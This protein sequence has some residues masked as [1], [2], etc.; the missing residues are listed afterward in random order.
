MF[1]MT[2][3]TTVGTASSVQY[4]EAYEQ[5]TGDVTFSGNL[6]ETHQYIMVFNDGYSVR[7]ND[8]FVVTSEAKLTGVDP[9][10][11]NKKYLQTLSSGTT[12]FYAYAASCNISDRNNIKVE[13]IDSSGKTAATSRYESSS[14]YHLMTA[15]S[16]LSPGSY[17][18]K[19]T[20]NNLVCSESLTVVS[21]NEAA[22]QY[23]FSQTIFNER[24]YLGVSLESATLNPANLTYKVVMADGTEKEAVYHRGLY[25]NAYD[26]NYFV[27]VVNEALTELDYNNSATLQMYNGSS[28]ITPT[29]SNNVSL[30]YVNEVDAP[31]IYDEYNTAGTTVELFVEGLSSASGTFSICAYDD[32]TKTGVSVNAASSSETSVVFNKSDLNEIHTIYPLTAENQGSSNKEFYIELNG[33][34][35]SYIWSYGYNGLGN[36]ILDDTFGFQNAYTNRLYE[37]LNLPHMTY[38]SY[39][40]A[41]SESELASKSYQPIEAGLL[42]QLKNQTEAQTVYAQFKTSDGAESDV[43]TA[44]ITIDTVSPAFTILSE[45]PEAFIVDEYNQFTISLEVN[46]DEAGKIHYDFYDADNNKIGYDDSTSSVSSG[47][48]TASRSVYAG[49]YNYE[50][51]ATLVIYMTD[52]AGNKS[53]EYSFPVSVF[54]QYTEYTSGE[55]YLKINNETGMIVEAMST[56]TT[57]RIPSEINGVDVTSIGEYAVYNNGEALRISIPETVTSIDAY[58]FSDLNE[59]TLLVRENSAALSYAVANDIPYEIVPYLEADVTKTTGGAYSVAVTPHTL[60]SANIVVA[61]YLNGRL[62]AFDSK[63]YTGEALDFSISEAIDEVKVMAWESLTTLKPLCEAKAVHG[64]KFITE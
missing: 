55:T 38:A 13:L 58:A 51:A 54:R 27:V 53:E 33:E 50:D 15:A 36:G 44:S 29:Y 52:L 48:S 42:Y 32:L 41:A 16:P 6:D 62:V 23:V 17:T 2:T 8:A 21:G 4:D 47:T 26:Y 3:G 43:Q 28:F 57:L 10:D 40:L 22:W 63:A 49:G 24:T 7:V 12:S 25:T 56:G 59:F 45:V 39:R 18:L 19:A 34:Y 1:D 20:Y 14:S 30:S 64:R 9:Y 60:D 61:G 31:F 37:V 5:I 35:L 46:T 11:T